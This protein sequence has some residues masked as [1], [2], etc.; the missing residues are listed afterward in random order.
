LYV[1][2]GTATLAGCNII[3][4]TGWEGAGLENSSGTVTLSALQIKN[5]T[6][7]DWGGGILAKLGTT[8]LNAV[9]FDENFAGSGGPKIAYTG[10]LGENTI[11]S[12]TD[13][14]GIVQ[15][16]DIVPKS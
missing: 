11:I 14:T 13:C 6:A 2:A 7:N 15:P 4:N 8:T 9:T 3:G 1:S 5:N 16:D 12:L 10:V